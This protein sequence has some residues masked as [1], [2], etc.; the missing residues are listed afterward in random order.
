METMAQLPPAIAG[1]SRLERACFS[2]MNEPPAPAALPAGP[3]AG[4]LRRLCSSYKTLLLSGELL[5]AAGRLERLDVLCGDY[6]ASCG[7]A[8]DRERFWRWCEGHPP[9]RQLH[10]SLGYQVSSH[11]TVAINALRD[12][13]PALRVECRIRHGNSFEEEF[14][15]SV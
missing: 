12:V 4:S 15:H 13:R 6:V 5:G 7:D 2:N 10:L 8:S 14:E 3:W 9:L 11:V 1:L